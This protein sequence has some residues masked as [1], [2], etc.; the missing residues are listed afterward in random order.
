MKARLEAALKGYRQIKQYGA[1]YLIINGT[2]TDKITEISMVCDVTKIS[3]KTLLNHVTPGRIKKRSFGCGPRTILGSAVEQEIVDY[4]VWMDNEGWPLSWRKIRIIARD[5]ARKH[6][7]KKFSASNRW[8]NWFKKR[9]P[10]LSTRL[11]ENLERTRV[12]GMNKAQTQKYFDLLEKV[13]CHCATLNGDGELPP[14]LIY[15]LDEAGVDQVSEMDGER[16]VVVL[17][18]K[19]TPT[20]RKTSAD[21]THLSAAACVAG[22]GWRAK[23]MYA[24][25]GKVRKEATLPMCPPGT[26]YIMTTK[27]Y[28]DDLGF[29]EYIKFLVNQLP[30]DGKWRVLIF[31]G[32]G[33]HT[34]V[35]STLDY[36]VENRIHAV[37]MP[38]HTSQFLQPLDVSCFGPVKHEFRLSLSDIQF[39]LGTEAIT[40]WE[41]PCVFEMAMEQGCSP[42]NIRSGFKKCGITGISSQEWMEMHK[43]LFQISAALNESRVQTH[44]THKR[45]AEIGDDALVKIH[46]TLQMDGLDS[47]LKAALS[48]LKNMI[49]PCVAVAKKL[50]PALC[51]PPKEVKK[52]RRVGPAVNSLDELQSAAKWVTDEKRR[53]RID[54]KVRGLAI[55]HEN[56]ERDQAEKDCQKEAKLQE[57]EEKERGIEAVRK[58]LIQHEALQPNGILDKK[59]IVHFYVTNKE[60]I[61]GI[62]GTSIPASK[63]TKTNLVQVILEHY[64]QILDM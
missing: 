39:K 34:M 2:M 10:E 7:I 45:A 54:E 8:K 11:A 56:N 63:H 28:F 3:Y 53:L 9:H 48:E 55:R 42:S 51:S 1:T 33:A 32:Y 18:I 5:I 17:K 43:D 46:S 13:K 16:H 59:A 49:E 40:K 24:L 41:L 38:S 57:K 62:I 44:L 29:F 4:I 58:L 6:D 61:D 19:K 37:C 25:K 36:L 15:N 30:K 23:T 35:K 22:D 47:P 20:Y 26:Q 52:R 50:G 12:G 21:R 27:G 60:D 31:D 64:D 14:S